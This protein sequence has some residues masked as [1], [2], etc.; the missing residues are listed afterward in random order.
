MQHGYT[1]KWSQ[2]RIRSG[3]SSGNCHQPTAP[4]FGR[5]FR[6]RSSQ[7]KTPGSLGLDQSQRRRAESNPKVFGFGFNVQAKKRVPLYSGRKSA[8]WHGS[9][10]GPHNT[11]GYKG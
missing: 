7:A 10:I 3:V 4:G 11:P 9:Q 8:Y 2:N 1:A 5:R 6:L